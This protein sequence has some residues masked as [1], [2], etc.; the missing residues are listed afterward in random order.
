MTVLQYLSILATV[1]Y[2]HPHECVEVKLQN[3]AA[4]PANAK[5]LK[6]KN[7]MQVY[8]GYEGSDHVYG[9]AYVYPASNGINMYFY[10]WGLPE[11]SSGGIHVHTGDTCEN[12]SLVGGHYYNTTLY[13]PLNEP[14]RSNT[15]WWQSDGE[16][17][18]E[19]DFVVDTGF[20][21]E[22]HN[23]HAVVVHN[24]AGTRIGCQ[25]LVTDDDACDFYDTAEYYCPGGSSSQCVA[26]VAECEDEQL[27]SSL[28]DPPPEKDTVRC[29]EVEHDWDEYD[30]E[31]KAMWE[32]FDINQTIWD[33]MY[34]FPE[35]LLEK[36]WVDLSS[37]EQQSATLCYTEDSWNDYFCGT[38]LQTIMKRKTCFMLVIDESTEEECN[39]ITT[40]EGCAKMYGCG[41][42]TDTMTCNMKCTADNFINCAVTESQCVAETVEYMTGNCDLR[43]GTAGWNQATQ[44][45]RLLEDAKPVGPNDDVV[46][47][48]F[49]FGGT[50]GSPWAPY[51]TGAFG[52]PRPVP[53]GPPVSPE[54][55][56][57]G[58][59]TPA[60][61]CS[62]NSECVE[63]GNCCY[64]YE[65][66]CVF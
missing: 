56:L 59:R 13:T 39:D 64:D 9:L 6:L 30:S 36:C 14:W 44:R 43:C 41:W 17:S 2:A 51:G 52:P 19:N 23:T 63:K 35:T 65:D 48:A 46:E 38:K 54:P 31:T 5:V 42:N 15:T 18:A 49:F 28:N 25:T 27:Y 12:A 61:E 34:Y 22:A 26:D 20:E 16:G 45:R 57:A 24:N 21:F 1:A 4:L 29:G 40:C 50:W 8:P 58:S 37:A 33:N 10:L 32:F 11:S 60:C 7:E 62:C 66:R 47:R 3:G 55:C 53:A